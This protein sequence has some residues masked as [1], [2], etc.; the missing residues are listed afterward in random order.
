M[1]RTRIRTVEFE[2][3]IRKAAE[4][5]YD[6]GNPKEIFDRIGLRPFLNLELEKLGREREEDTEKEEDSYLQH[7][8]KCLLGEL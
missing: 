5:E 8:G 7:F 4:I 2:E 3:V 6:E 1:A